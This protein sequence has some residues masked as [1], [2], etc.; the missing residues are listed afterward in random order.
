MEAICPSCG[1][2]NPAVARFC[3]SCA[4]PLSERSCA[5]CSSPL[6]AG[7]RFCPTCGAAAPA[8]EEQPGAPAEERRIVTV[9]F[10]DIVGF[11]TRSDGA[12]PEDVRR[13]LLP[14]HGRVKQDIERFGGTLDKFIGDAAMGVFGAPVAHE[15]DPERAVCAALRILDTIRELNEEDPTLDINVRVGINT[16]EAFVTFASGPVVGENVAG[17]VVNTASRLQG[18]APPGGIVIGESTDRATRGRFEVEE[19][20]PVSVKG[21]AEP[22]RLWKVLGRREAPVETAPTTAFVGREAELDFLARTYDWALLNS[23]LRMIAIVGEPGIGK[24]RLVEEFHTRLQER[25]GPPTWLRGRCLP[26]G[27]AITFLPLRTIV[28]RHAGIADA[29][30]PQEATTRLALSVDALGAEAVEQE[31]LLAR[32]GPLVGAG[33]TESVSRE[34]VFGAWSRYLELVAAR[35]AVLVFEDVGWADPAL[36]DFIRHAAERL[37][38]LPVL[39][40]VTA[41]PELLQDDPSWAGR[42]D[43]TLLE[44]P[45]LSDEATDRLLAELLPEQGLSGSTRAALRERAGGSPFFAIE[46]AQMVAESA[47]S[48]GSGADGMP[49]PDSLHGVVA[50]RLDALTIAH[51]SA[52]HDAAVLGDRFWPGAIAAMSGAAPLAAE[53]AVDDLVRR[54]L[55]VPARDPS[56]AG[57]RE[58]SFTNVLVREVAYRQV[59]KAARMRKHRAA[60]EWLVS[61]LGD[62]APERAELLAFHF[63]NAVELAKETG[64]EI[65]AELQDEARDYLY[66]AGDRASRLDVGRAF[67]YLRRALELTGAGHPARPE[68]IT[69]VVQTGRRAGI[70][71]SDEAEALMVEAVEQLRTAGDLRRAGQAMVRRSRQL[72]MLGEAATAR[73][74]LSEAIQILER[75]PKGVELADAYTARAEEEMLAGWPRECL[76]WADR[77]IGLLGGVGGSAEVRVMAYQLRGMARCELGDDGGLEDL[78]EALQIAYHLGLALETAQSRTYLGETTWQLEG[79]AR[80]I[81]FHERAMEECL[82]RGLSSEAMWAGA[83]SVWMLYDLGEWD[84]IL[85]RAEEVAAWDAEHGSGSL[86]AIVA[87]YRVRVLLHRGRAAEVGSDEV[88]VFVRLARQFKDLQTLAP[89]LATAVLAAADAGDADRAVELLEEFHTATRGRS[90]LYREAH[91][92]DLVEACI[93]VDR[94]PLAHTLLEGA[95]G[96]APRQ[97]HCVTS[98]G[99]LLAAAQGEHEEALEL[100]GLASEGWGVFGAPFERARADLGAGLAL[101][102][103]GRQEEAAERLGS[104]RTTFEELHAEPW[105]ARASAP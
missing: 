42:A 75:E 40:I 74:V 96:I 53:E 10:A 71:G 26:F 27:E 92:P 56:I 7:A 94:L 68:I 5:A 25:A 45:R 34:E 63:S 41:R 32:L 82:Q 47:A 31:W 59:P 28:R 14:F 52:A 101:R 6:P 87:P 104:A 105:L 3:M 86:Q 64:E 33:G 80:G 1:T 58:L 18:I 29:D 76:E 16:G 50:A 12:D 60:G 49:V 51:R 55:A 83:E 81:V 85:V 35:P 98:A 21:K 62:R 24:S 30:S 2:P 17:D 88:E 38:A 79:P 69:K 9:M 46:F 48:G 13:T 90:G 11:T 8:A 37:S 65:P 44:L 4:T 43:T 97:R 61:V 39:M 99:A 72:A 23:T 77:A 67:D 22:L 89:A 19:L 66:L 78:G 54:G 100:F 102:A 15:D 36:L 103:L 95:E 73:A 84:R 91:L 93:R 57:Q 70:M 20:E